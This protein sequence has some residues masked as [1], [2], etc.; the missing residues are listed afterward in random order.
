VTRIRGFTLVELLV[1][2]AIIGVLVALL[3]PAVQAAREAARRAQCVNNLK[4][5]SLAMTNYQDVHKAL[6]M[7][8]FSCCWGTWQMAILPYIEEQALADLYQWNPKTPANTFDYDYTYDSAK[9]ATATRPAIRNLELTQKRITS[10]TCPSDEPQVNTTFVAGGTY[11]NYVANY[12]NTNHVGS[13]CLAA[14][15][16]KYAGSPFIGNDSDPTPKVTTF[17]K[18]IDGL[19]K[20][21]MFSETVQGND[22]DLRGFTWWGW[23]AGF[24]TTATP[25]SNDL[26]YMQQQIYCKPYTPNPPCGGA[27]GG[28]VFRAAARSRHPGGVNVSMCDGSVQFVVDDV[29][30][31]TW[32]AASTT[33]GDEVYSGLT[34]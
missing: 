11:H 23:S 26:D 34:P 27:S 30:L 24:E 33:R 8:N 16:V 22:D 7:G 15:C 4:Q 14:S 21:I 29:D 9:P 19:S 12:G 20:T 32:R 6:P 17:K 18:I 28:N 13:S 3:L 31:A 1:V 10:L 25:N 2:I 5:I